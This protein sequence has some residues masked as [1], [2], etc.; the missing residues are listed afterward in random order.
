MGWGN[1]SIFIFCSCDFIFPGGK[2]NCD[3]C[4]V[5]CTDEEQLKKHIE[6]KKHQAK[7]KSKSQSIFKCSVCNVTTTDQ[8]GLNMHL[9]V[10][11]F[12]MDH[13]ERKVYNVYFQGKAHHAMIRKGGYQDRGGYR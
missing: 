1:V 6:G 7:C 3:L 2:L 12:H 5:T 11:Y 4:M 8:N 13:G 10:N 9:Q